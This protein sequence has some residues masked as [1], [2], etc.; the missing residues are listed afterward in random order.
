MTL[1]NYIKSKNFYDGTKHYIMSYTV[2]REHK[3]E[4]YECYMKI[5]KKITKYFIILGYYKD[6]LEFGHE[7]VNYYFSTIFYSANF[8]LLSN[9]QFLASRSISWGSNQG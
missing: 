3:D 1:F 8:L 9:R 2:F 5:L 7:L 6:A 4:F